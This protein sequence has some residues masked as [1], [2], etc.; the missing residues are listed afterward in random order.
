MKPDHAASL[1]SERN[2]E[3]PIEV[4]KP[5]TDLARPPECQGIYVIS[6]RKWTDEPRLE[7]D[8]RYVGKAGNLRW[9]LGQAVAVLLGFG[10]SGALR[11]FHGRARRI[12]R[13]ICGSD[14]KK[15]ATL[16]IGWR[17]LT[18][19]ECVDCEEA[20]LFRKFYDTGK[21]SHAKMPKCSRP[22]HPH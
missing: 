2:W 13:D 3:G 8:V 9:R 16:F 20:K 1:A 22:N 18:S 10:P 7:A 4:G 12:F 11:Y 15:S 19:G 14:I 17:E 6:E 5:T 21:L